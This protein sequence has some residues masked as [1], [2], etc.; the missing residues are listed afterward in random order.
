MKRCG[1]I[2]LWGIFLLMVSSFLVDSAA[3]AEKHQRMQVSLAWQPVFTAKEDMSR[4]PRQ[5][6]LNV[7][8]PCW[9]TIIDAQG[10][11]VSKASSSYV[12]GA[13]ERG[14]AVW[15]L[16]T[17]DFDPE[18]TSQLLRN[19]AGRAAAINN[20]LALAGQYELDGINLDFENIEEADKALLTEFV[21][22]ISAALR[23]AKLVVSLDVT[24]PSASPR[25]SLCYDRKAL[26][27]QVDYVMLMAYDEHGSASNKSGS[28]ASLPWVENAVREVL[29]EVPSSKLVLG[30]PLY[31]RLWQEKDG[32]V[33]VNTL[34][35]QAA[36]KM[37]QSKGIQRQWLA[38]EGQY[39]FSYWSEGAFCRVWQE[40]ARSLALKLSL[41][42]RYDLAGIA[43]WRRGFE[44][45]DVWQML[46][47]RF[48]PEQ[49]YHGAEQ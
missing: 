41:V 14:Y 32:K 31:M 1:K 10:N 29:Q 21:S 44:T 34:S 6:S 40:D 8:S 24:V 20:I 36:E 4:L 5:E 39:Y 43:L 46:A 17:N 33:S 7:V 35:M 47:Q 15:A 27:Q 45:A 25:W 28:V 38:E 49:L 37:Y 26:A 13:H 23:R 22:E 2:F 12:A 18:M 42:S 11:I 9:F 30:M 3:M 16:V 19:P 48:I